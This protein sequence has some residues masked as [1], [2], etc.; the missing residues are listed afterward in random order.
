[1]ENITNAKITEFKIIQGVWGNG[2][3][4]YNVQVIYNDQY[5]GFG[6]FV[7]TYR[8]ALDYIEKIIEENKGE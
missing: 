8:D 5:C 6:K 2:E 4:N 3:Y 1:M 7:K